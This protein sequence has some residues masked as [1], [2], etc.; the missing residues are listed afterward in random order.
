[1][2]VCVCVYIYNAFSPQGVTFDHASI[3]DVLGKR[4]RKVTKGKRQL[5][6]AVRFRCGVGVMS[7]CFPRRQLSDALGVRMGS[8]I[9]YIHLC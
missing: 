5:E 7:K 4:K 6:D 3:F 9:L 1:V 8:I 2:C